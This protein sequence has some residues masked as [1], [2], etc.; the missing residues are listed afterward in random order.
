MFFYSV[1]SFS[2]KDR[3]RLTI[4]SCVLCVWRFVL[5]GKERTKGVV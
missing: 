5:F 3:S 4:V 2:S 1:H